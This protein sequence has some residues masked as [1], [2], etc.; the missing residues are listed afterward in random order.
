MLTKFHF[1]AFVIILLSMFADQSDATQR[2]VIDSLKKKA[3]ESDNLQQRVEIYTRLAKLYEEVHPDSANY[4][5]YAALKL[6][7]S[8]TP[9]EILGQIYD[10]IGHFAVMH[11]SLDKAKEAYLQS[12]E[13]FKAAQNW[14]ELIH[15]YM[16]IGNIYLVKDQLVDALTYYHKGIETA[17][18]YNIPARLPQFYLNIGTIYYQANSYDDALR[19]FNLSLSRFQ[20]GRDSTNIGITLGNIAAVH[21][22]L[23]ELDSSEINHRKALEI[24][25]SLHDHANMSHSYMNLGEVLAQQDNDTA[26]LRYLR[27]CLDEYHKIGN[28]YAGPRSV[29]LAPAFARI[30]KM[31]LKMHRPD[32]ALLYLNKGFELAKESSQLSLMAQACQDLSSL[33][34]QRSRLDSSLYYLKLHSKYYEQQLNEENIHALSYQ[35]AKFEFDQRVKAAELAQLKA[36]VQRNRIYLIMSVVIGGLS[37][38]A[39][40]LFLLVKLGRN[41]LKE[42]AL[43]KINLENELE[44]RNKELTTHVMYQV[45]NK[46]FILKISEKLKNASLV[47]NPAY[48][49][50]LKEIISE[51]DMD[52]NM[53]SWKEFEIRFQRVYINFFRNLSAK[54]PD[55][56][57]NELRTCAFLKLN[58]STKDIASIT[59]QTIN[60]IDVARHRLR[61]KLG[62]GKDENLVSFI[63]Q[64]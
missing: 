27:L 10:C 9:P 12:G 58:L 40:V 2:S 44:F 5:A 49:Q 53:D 54:F 39:A 13:Y 63:S 17:E 38:V 60:S 51:M 48:S 25:K 22:K 36:D 20:V 35:A 23:N 1:T 59:Y 43:K 57:P 61:Q 14:F 32:S 42:A 6:S 30:G 28:E 52:S 47:N 56:T 21:S 3:E 26:A 16:V 37:I 29:I 8:K 64:F 62:L 50:M 7:N 31:Y 19:Y 45:K 11:D 41:R 15:V 55:L 24:F 46:E 18:K 4:F 34:E 33:W